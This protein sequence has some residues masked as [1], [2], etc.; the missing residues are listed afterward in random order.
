MLSVSEKVM[1]GRRI[2]F[3]QIKPANVFIIPLVL[4]LF[5]SCQKKS[6]IDSVQC[7]SVGYVID[8][9]NYKGKILKTDTAIAWPQVC[10]SELNRFLALSKSYQPVCGRPGCYLRLVIWK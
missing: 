7:R 2:R 1:G 4:A 6:A 10:N 5:G 8:S 3:P 9:L